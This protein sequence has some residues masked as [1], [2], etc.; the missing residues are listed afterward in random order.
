VAGGTAA[1]AISVAG[2]TERVP[3]NAAR[4]DSESELNGNTLIWNYPAS[5]VRNDEQNEGIGY[6][7]IRFRAFD[8]VGNT[9]SV[10]PVLQF[11]LNSTVG[12]IAAGESYE[13]YQADWFRFRIGVPRTYDGVSG[14]RASVQP[15][16]WP[17]VRT[18]YGHEGAMRELVVKSPSVQTEGTII[19]EGE[20]RPAGTTLPRQLHCQFEVQ[21]SQQAPLGRAVVADGRATFDVTTLGLPEGVTAG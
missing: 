16:Q 17:A 18:T 4:V 11:R 7:S 12:D 13:E 9:G 14:L 2:C 10:D 1:A 19:V 5:V 21:A 8:M 15:P 6:A 20:F 3:G